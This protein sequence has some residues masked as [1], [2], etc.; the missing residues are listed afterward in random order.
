MIPESHN[1]IL[2]LSVSGQEDCYS[3]TGLQ[4]ALE[5]I[6]TPLLQKL[7]MEDMQ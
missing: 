7:Y 5:V 4:D 3:V 2:K 1:N 6:I